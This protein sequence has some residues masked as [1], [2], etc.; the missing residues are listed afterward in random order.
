MKKALLLTPPHS[1]SYRSKIMLGD[2]LALNAVQAKLESLDYTVIT[3]DSSLYDYELNYLTSY[4]KDPSLSLIGISVMSTS[5]LSHIKLIIGQIRSYSKQVIIV[6]GGNAVTLDPNAFVGIGA[7]YI[8]KGSSLSVYDNLFSNIINKKSSWDCIIDASTYSLSLTNNCFSYNIQHRQNLYASHVSDHIVSIESSRGCYGKCHFCTI[9]Y[10]YKGNWIPRDL[11][12]LKKE[13]RLIRCALPTCTQLRFVDGNFL[14]GGIR[15]YQRILELAHFLHYNNFHY[16]IECREN[17]IN[18]E[19]FSQ[20]KKLGLCG[21]FIGVE[22][23]N[24]EILKI[25]NKGIS[26]NDSLMKIK[27][28]QKLRI[29]SSLGFIMITPTT[30][31]KIIIEN[32]DFLEKIGFGIR[33]KHF[34]STLIFYKNS[35]WW[36]NLNAPESETEHQL[37]FKVADKICEKLVYFNNICLKKHLQV[38]ENEHTLG[39]FLERG[40]ETF[41]T[42]AWEIDSLFSKTCIRIFRSLL[43]DIDQCSLSEIDSLCDTYMLLLNNELL[44]IISLCKNI[45]IAP[46]VALAS[47]W[48]RLYHCE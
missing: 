23:V 42:D 38:L 5:S 19:L 25:L 32:L 29:P 47:I 21:T 48:E 4:C 24:N 8:I 36:P 7:N 37:G 41:S 43:N 33:W 45:N 17:D 18:E 40:K 44:K 11:A 22:N 35:N 14:G 15:D 30:T 27:L 13:I 16:R 9:N 28:L 31:K 1:G 46:E 12:D 34:F 26:S 3:L 20:L 10:E 39:I 6:L 2:S